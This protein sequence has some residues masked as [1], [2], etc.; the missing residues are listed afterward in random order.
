MKRPIPNYFIV[1]A[2]KCATTF[3]AEHLR[4]HPEV[5]MTEPKEPQHFSRDICP[6]LTRFIDPH[7]YAAL[8]ASVGGEKAIGEA[9][10]WYLYSKVAASA[11]YRVNPRARIIVM[12]RNPVDFMYSMHSQLLYGGHEWINDFEQAIDLG[13]RERM[14]MEPRSMSLFECG[15]EYRK[16]ARFC[17][18]I[19]RYT[20]LFGRERIHFIL[21][22]DVR[23]SPEN[24]YADVLRFLEV[25]DSFRPHFKIVNPNKR[26]RSTWMMDLLRSRWPLKRLFAR[27]LPLAARRRIV[28]FVVGT[29]TEPV[30]RPPMDPGLRERLSLEFEPEVRKLAELVGRDLSSWMPASGD[31]VD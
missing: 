6:E 24:V 19:S 29:A 4:M 25:D 8:F 30:P 11:I 21:L 27:S 12:L 26:I 10:T 1:G 15:F 13:F 3:M 17:H 2:H 20:R 31:P 5:F 9:S 7:E 18:Q 22:D 28:D 14:T 23:H 16:A